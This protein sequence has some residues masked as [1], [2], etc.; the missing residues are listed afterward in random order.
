MK[1]NVLN[2]VRHPPTETKFSP[3]Y[4]AQQRAWNERYS[5]HGRNAVWW[6]R[7]A[8]GCI[9]IAGLAVTGLVYD[10]SLSKF[11]PYVVERD[12]LG[13]EVAIGPVARATPCDAR[14][15]QAELRRWLY[16]VRTVSADMEAEK[17]NIWEAYHHTNAKGPA[18]GE[19]DEWFSKNIPWLRAQEHIVTITTGGMLAADP[20]SV[21]NWLG[22]WKEETRSR[23]G[24][25]EG[26]P[27]SKQVSFIVSCHP[28]QTETEF[29]DNPSGV[30]V[31]AVNWIN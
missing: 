5:I 9:G 20:T 2:L 25:L 23:D 22:N 21:T 29:K 7:T 26:L 18:K 10:D 28:P 13:D 31:D 27:E 11:T 30:F 15:I 8:F 6:R 17:H 14:I 19:L 16:D 4:Q 3:V 12:Q 1:L 24:I